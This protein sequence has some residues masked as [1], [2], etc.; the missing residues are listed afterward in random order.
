MH[1]AATQVMICQHPEEYLPL[2]SGFI[3]DATVLGTWL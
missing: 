3:N 1:H 2:P